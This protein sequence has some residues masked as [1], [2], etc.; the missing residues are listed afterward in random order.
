MTAWIVMI[1]AGL[2]SLAFRLSIVALIDRIETPDWL[3]KLA[4]YVVPAA[5]AGIAAAALAAPVRAGGVEAIGPVVA[6]LVTAGVAARRHSVHLAFLG[7]LASLWITTALIA[8][9]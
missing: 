4:A 7:G 2:G 6:V 1:G 8:L 3:E 9:A 5:F